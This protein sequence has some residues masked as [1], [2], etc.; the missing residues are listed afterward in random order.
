MDLPKLTSISIGDRSLNQT[1]SFTFKSIISYCYQGDL[2]NLATVHFGDYAFF[3][4]SELN[5]TS[6]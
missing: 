3:E 2:P 6:N 4:M 1:N 5:V